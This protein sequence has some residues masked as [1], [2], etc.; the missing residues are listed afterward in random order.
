MVTYRQQPP[1]PA[2]PR[3]TDYFD[4]IFQDPSSP[5]HAM[6]ITHRAGQNVLVSTT[7]AFTIASSTY[8]LTTSNAMFCSIQQANLGT[9]QSLLLY[10]VSSHEHGSSGSQAMMTGLSA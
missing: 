7:I 1:H 8:S 9:A 5:L 4:I 10:F 3:I 6:A 2:Q